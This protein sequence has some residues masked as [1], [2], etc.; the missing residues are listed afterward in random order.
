ML[1]CFLSIGTLHA[2]TTVEKV[3]NGQY[4]TPQERAA[5][6]DQKMKQGLGL[7]DEQMPK[8]H[9]INL[10]YSIRTENEVANAQLSTWSKYRKITAIQADKD[11]ELKKVLNAEQ[12]KKYAKKRDELM[13]E[14]MKAMLF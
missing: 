12:F 11:K 9:D 14:G 13:W 8:I 3:K 10:R 4:G 6:L 2:Q 7:T 5:E 1:L